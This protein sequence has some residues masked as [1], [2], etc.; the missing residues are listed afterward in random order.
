MAKRSNL[1]RREGRDVDSIK[2]LRKGG[3]PDHLLLRFEGQGSS[4]NDP[5]TTST[6]GETISMGAT[7]VGPSE[8]GM[9][10]KSPMSIVNRDDPVEEPG[11]SDFLPL[12][13]GYSKGVA[14]PGTGVLTTD[15]EEALKK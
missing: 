10:S 9:G 3:S 1:S 15:A 6:G 11:G 8:V 7:H 14:F 4:P 2:S 12:T 5:G 13:S